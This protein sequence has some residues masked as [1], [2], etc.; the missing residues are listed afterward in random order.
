MDSTKDP[1][2]RMGL[3]RIPLQPSRLSCTEEDG[4][5]PVLE[6]CQENGLPLPTFHRVRT[7]NKI[8]F[9]QAK[10]YV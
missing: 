10:L 7:K 4:V 2:R 1:S 8:P 5:N 3:S 9:R 6:S